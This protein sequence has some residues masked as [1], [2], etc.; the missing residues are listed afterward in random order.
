[1][2]TLEALGLGERVRK[3]D[4][5]VLTSYWIYIPSLKSKPDM[6]R[7]LNELKALGITEYSPILEGG[8]WHYAISLGIFRKEDSAA[9]YLALLRGKGVRS[10]QLGEREQRTIQTFLLIRDPTDAQ[11][12]QLANLRNDYSGSDLRAVDCP[13]S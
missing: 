2:T 10:A 13:P 4:G 3:I 5:A 11:T 9:R 6:E 8:R 12:T 1:M 7:K